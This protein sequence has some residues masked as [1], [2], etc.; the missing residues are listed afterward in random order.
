MEDH[1]PSLINSTMVTAIRLKLINMTSEHQRLRR[2]LQF[3][4]VATLSAVIPVQ[5]WGAGSWIIRARLRRPT[6]LEIRKQKRHSDTT[7]L[8]F[9]PAASAPTT[10][11]S[12]VLVAI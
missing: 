9:W 3:L 7:R 1:W 8:Q 6:E 5:H 11:A 4:M 10:S 12:P 2:R